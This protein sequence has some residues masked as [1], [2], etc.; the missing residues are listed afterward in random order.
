MRRRR[1]I[2]DR[3]KEGR[4]RGRERQRKGASPSGFIQFVMNI[5]FKY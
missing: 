2:G 4:E 3:M 5:K 1:R